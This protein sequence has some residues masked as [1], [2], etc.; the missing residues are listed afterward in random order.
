MWEESMIRER[1]LKAGKASLRSRVKRRC[2]M[3]REMFTNRNSIRGSIP[4][5]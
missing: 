5:S 4:T 1:S 2:E 3:L